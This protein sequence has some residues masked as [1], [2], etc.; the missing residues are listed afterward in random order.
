MGRD[1]RRRRGPPSRQL[2]HVG[3]LAQTAADAALLYELL[4]D[5]P[6]TL[7]EEVPPGIKLA[8][9]DGYFSIGWAP[10]STRRW[11]RRSTRWPRGTRVSTQSIPH[12]LDIAP[13]YLHLVLADAAALHVRLPERRPH[14]YTPNVRLRLEMGRHVLGEDYV[15]AQH[16]RAVLRREIDRP[17]RRRCAGAAGAVDR[18]AAHRRRQRG[19]RRWTEPVR[20]AMLR[21]TQPFNLSGH[22]AIS[23]LRDDRGRMP[24]G[25]QLVGHHGRTSDLL[26]VA[27]AV[28]QALDAG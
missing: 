13:V 16:G 2:D 3:P 24:V 6:A 4:G 28:E 10:A 22:P 18:S 12:A 9:L 1:R 25:L 15:R 20:T 11:R 8:M 5:R 27:H 19:G 26:R 14:A 17:R 21:C 7:T 23:L